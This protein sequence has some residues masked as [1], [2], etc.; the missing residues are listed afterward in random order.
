MKWIWGKIYRFC[1]NSFALE[2]ECA[3]D[4]LQVTVLCQ[5]QLIQKKQF[6]PGESLIVQW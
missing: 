5:G 3:E 2:A 6:P 1:G 4:F